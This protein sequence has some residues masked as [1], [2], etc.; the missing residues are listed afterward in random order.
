MIPFF[1]L[2]L[3]VLFFLPGIG[4]CASPDFSVPRWKTLP[5]SVSHFPPVP[6][7][8]SVQTDPRTPPVQETLVLHGIH[9][10]G[11]VLIIPSGGILYDA[12]PVAQSIRP[13][14]K[15]IFL[16]TESV[17]LKTNLRIDRRKNVTI[18][19][20]QA[21]LVGNHLIRYVSPAHL[22]QKEVPAI[23]WQT[24]DGVAIR[25]HP[26]TQVSGHAPWPRDSTFI[27]LRYDRVSSGS[28][29]YKSLSAPW[30]SSETW[31][32][33]RMTT[34]IGFNSV[35]PE[36]PRFRIVPI[37]CPVGH[38]IGLMIYN[39]QPVVLRPGEKNVFL[40]GYLSLHP[41]IPASGNPS[42]EINGSRFPLKSSF[43]TF[44]TARNTSGIQYLSAL[45]H[46]FSG[47]PGFLHPNPYAQV[48][49]HDSKP[50][51]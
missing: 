38:H 36:D 24:I 50:V 26:V 28:V 7:W 21:S 39:S 41:E 15:G 25:K 34:V 44:G 4:E 13:G 40:G 3:S 46:A 32:I 48:Q 31:K 2:F 37:A 14:Q 45:F 29:H 9:R 5:D 1:L 8:K 35:L 23:L 16:G 18:R 30:F 42:I 33:G 19:R 49:K 20:G 10:F 22:G 12:S 27:R 47:L 17:L 43:L 51:F 11:R 6:G